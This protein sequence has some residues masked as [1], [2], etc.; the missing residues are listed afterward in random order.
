MKIL[1]EFGREEIAK[2]YVAS[3]RNDHTHIVE[4]VESLQPP[5]PRDQK[6]VLI[7]SSS[8]GCP[9]KCRMCDAGGSYTGRL[10]AEEIIAQVDH[11]V[12]RR[13]PD[14][15]VPVKKFKVQFARMG[16]PTLNPN[17][18]DALNLLPERFDA[19]GLMACVSTIAPGG[20]KGFFDRMTDIKNELYA[21]GQ[22]QLQ[23]SIHTTDEEKRDWLIPGRK[24]TF[25]EISRF[26]DEF[27]VRGDRKLAL[28]F[29]LAQGLPVEPKAI[30]DC[31]DPDKFLV[32]LTPLNPTTR[33]KLNRLESALDPMDSRCCG[34]LI[35]AFNHLG[36][37]AIL[38][39]GELE[40][41][42]IG[43]NC[44]QYVSMFD[45]NGLTLKRDYETLKYRLA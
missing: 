17:V 41:N 39:I 37:E 15:R 25:D 34:E 27:F 31:F 6:W 13:F 22:F 33:A 7:V 10:D 18:L 36:F 2:V 14:V 40:E 8:F 20:S 24:W 3:M 45:S 44:G 32:K 30:A 43:S 26:G 11:M 9:I 29:A 5:V 38:S 35:Q 1:G 16:E 21:N 28:N 19:P 4:F 42:K 23:F 12:R